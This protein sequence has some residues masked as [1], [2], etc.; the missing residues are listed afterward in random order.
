MKRIETRN[1][2]QVRIVRVNGARI[3]SHAQYRFLL[4]SA[5]GYVLLDVDDVNGRGIVRVPVMLNNGSGP[6]SVGAPAAPR[7]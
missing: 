1:G 3:N 5:D 2:K 6:I 7:R 4:S